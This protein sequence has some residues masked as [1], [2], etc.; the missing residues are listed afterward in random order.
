MLFGTLVTS[1]LKYLAPNFSFEIID[2]TFH[3]HMCLIIP[4]AFFLNASIIC[5]N[6]AVAYISI[7]MIQILKGLSPVMVYL[8]S[9]LLGAAQF[10]AKITG[11][12]LLI[13][14][15]I[16]VASSQ[17][18]QTDLYGISAQSI[19]IVSDSCRLV[20]MQKLL[21]SR[22][23]TFDPAT[24]FYHLAPF[25]ALLGAMTRVFTPFPTISEVRDVWAALLLN[26]TFTS[27]LNL[28][29]LF[30]V[31]RATAPVQTATDLLSDTKDFFS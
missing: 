2:M 1:I 31:S 26:C 23:F 30:V 7:T 14:L 8:I 25:C 20:L 10:S 11:T 27:M 12:L 24:L 9:L 4:V 15:G 3:E 16:F 28:S 21:T 5:G 29:G 6:E 18:I 19:G 22:K 13:S 17:Y